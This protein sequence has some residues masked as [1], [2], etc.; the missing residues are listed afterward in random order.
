MTHTSRLI[1]L[2][3]ALIIC[4]SFSATT[5]LAEGGNTPESAAK[6]FTKAY[7]TL[8]ASIED[9]LSSDALTNENDVDMVELFFS[10]KEAEARSR[11][12]EMSYLKMHPLLIKTEVL[13]QT[14]DTAT[15]RVNTSAL[16]SINPVFRMVGWIF[17]LI[18]E[19]NFETT[20]PLVKEDGMWKVGPGVLVPMG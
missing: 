18:K 12:Y 2:L 19:H 10:K 11:G 20:L 14:E 5:A 8:D 1:S 6:G 13:E 17:G 15:V 4:L 7:Y 16:R 3:A 9:Y